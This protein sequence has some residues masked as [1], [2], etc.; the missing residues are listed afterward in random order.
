MCV[1]TDDEHEEVNFVVFMILKMFKCLL[2]NQR[3]DMPKKNWFNVNHKHIQKCKT[4][5]YK[6]FTVKKYFESCEMLASRAQRSCVLLQSESRNLIS[7]CI[8]HNV[9]INLI[10]IHILQLHDSAL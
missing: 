5:F 7:D 3:R 4:R 2:H 10:A 8:Y 6:F 1:L 9:Y